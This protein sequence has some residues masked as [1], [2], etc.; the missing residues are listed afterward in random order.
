MPARILVIYYSRTG[1][2]KRI[3]E[4]IAKAAGGDLEAIT[5]PSDRSGILGYLRSAY[6]AFRQRSVEIGPAAHDPSS[7]DLVVI[8]T[9]IWNM[10]VSPPVR[11]YLQREKDRL[12]TVAFFCTCGGSGGERA[13]TQMT[14]ECGKSPAT[15]LIVREAE[16]DRSAAAVARFLTD[17][18]AAL[19]ERAA[20]TTA[21]AT[22]E[23]RPSLH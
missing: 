2:T 12:P 17:L 22:G 4:E 21:P 7:Y 10:S 9:P 14:R 3:A 6:Q 15:T 23:V 16:L 20:G 11:S 19:P 18:D 8:G 13:F 5:D 1:H